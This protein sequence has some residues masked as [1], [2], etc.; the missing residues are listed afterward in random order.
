MRLNSDKFGLL[1]ITV[2][3]GNLFHSFQEFN[4]ED[5]R[6]AYFSN[7]DNIVNITFRYIV[8]I[9]P[10][11]L[12]KSYKLHGFYLIRYKTSIDNSLY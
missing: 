8:I 12:L 10:A 3:G 2:R 7:P 4:I 5:G 9:F 11:D 6:G 1:T